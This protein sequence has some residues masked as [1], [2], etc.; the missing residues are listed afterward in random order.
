MNVYEKE[1]AELKTDYKNLEQRV[2]TLERTT[3]RHDQQI[4]NMTE[5]LNKID[6]NTTWIKRTITGAIIT[7]VSTGIIG[8]TIAIVFGVWKG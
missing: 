8:G 7:A 2:G 5:K 4:I 6:D 3:D 1:L